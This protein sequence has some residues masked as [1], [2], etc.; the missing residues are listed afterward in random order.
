MY[1]VLNTYD[2]GDRATEISQELWER[3]VPTMLAMPDL[4]ATMAAESVED[5]F[6]GVSI[7]FFETQEAAQAYLDSGT[8]KSL[9]EEASFR[10]ASD[11]RIYRVLNSTFKP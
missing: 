8:A 7:T 1:I 9:D 3:H 4:L 11:R 2:R 10:T 6:R 5:G